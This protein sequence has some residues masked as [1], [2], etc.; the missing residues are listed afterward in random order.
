[1]KAVELGR[2]KKVVV[3]GK[4]FIIPLP[5]AYPYLLLDM[6]HLVVVLYMFVDNRD[7]A[8]TS[9]ANVFAFS[10]DGRI[11]WQVEPFSPPGLFSYG[12]LYMKLNEKDQ[13]WLRT[14][15]NEWA[16]IDQKS[17]SVLERILPTDSR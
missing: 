2:G 16:L 8:P 13:L 1:M 7:G 14:W 15:D 4:E 17:G 11:L 9:T 3:D 5:N 12:Y 10:R 6:A